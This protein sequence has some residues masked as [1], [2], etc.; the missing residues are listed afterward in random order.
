MKAYSVFSNP[1]T[2]VSSDQRASP[3]LR[4]ACL[5]VA[6]AIAGPL[7]ATT[8]VPP[9]FESLVGQAD[10]IVRA[11]VTAVHAEMISSGPNRHIVTTVELDVRQVIAGAPPAPLVL[12]MLGG[13]VG[14][15]E[16]RVE[17]AP[18]FQVGDEDILF[19]HGNGKSF[20]PLV[21]LMHGRYPVLKDAAGR[22][23]MARANGAPLYSEQEVSLPMG[24]ASK[25]KAEQADAAP[26][27]PD[28]FVRRIQATVI[29]STKPSLQ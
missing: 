19:V 11:V 28:E 1:A 10:Y 2:R 16:M 27:S 6:V 23:Y 4:I 9:K 22:E 15:E 8:V 5:L 14:A 20:T 29:A 25:I 12:T 17:G 7:R 3:L 13:K 18:K 26:L 24:A 21:A